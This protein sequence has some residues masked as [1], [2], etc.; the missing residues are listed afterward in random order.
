MS[1][2]TPVHAPPNA[3]RAAAPPVPATLADTGL[4]TTRSSSS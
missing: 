3:D 4:A 2:L 1:L